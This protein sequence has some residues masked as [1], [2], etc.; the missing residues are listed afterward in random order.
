MKLFLLIINLTLIS[1]S[2]HAR[3]GF[4]I[5]KYHNKFNYQG[6]ISF[7]DDKDGK[8]THLLSYQNINFLN[9]I[10]AKNIDSKSLVQDLGFAYRMR[11]TQT[12]PVFFDLG[13]DVNYFTVG[14]NS[15]S[16]F[17]GEDLE[18]Y[19]FD[20]SASVISFPC[21]RYFI[22]YSGLGFN[23]GSIMYRQT[24]K[25]KSSNEETLEKQHSSNLFSPFFKFGLQSYLG[26]SFSL[27]GE[28][29]QSLW[30]SKAHNQF[31]F[32]IGFEF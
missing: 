29:K 2:I 13:I 16:I 15:N 25:E 17:A 4:A 22:P 12:A 19:G 30:V 11:V 23:Y 24:K 6:I 3:D 21:P 28:Y 26:N 7:F 27:F 9:P 18:Y 8:I 5:D 14:E 10:F 31:Y 20:F 1:L 32:G